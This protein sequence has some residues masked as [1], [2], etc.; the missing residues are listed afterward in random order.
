MS[1]KDDL[2][3]IRL[4][5]PDNPDFNQAV[6]RVWDVIEKLEIQVSQ[7]KAEAARRGW[8]KDAAQKYFRVRH[9]AHRIAALGDLDHADERRHV[10]LQSLIDEARTVLYD[11][12]PMPREMDEHFDGTE[13]QAAAYERLR[14]WP[15]SRDYIERTIETVRNHRDSENMWPQWANILA[16]EIERLWAE[17][18]S[19]E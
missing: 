15:T 10:T 14:T 2:G 1:W 5:G 13:A 8:P 6:R 19:R 12:K 17:D 9:F 11:E 18:L 4:E 3:K 7:W 16:D